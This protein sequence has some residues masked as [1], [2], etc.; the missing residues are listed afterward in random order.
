M[1]WIDSTRFWLYKLPPRSTLISFFLFSSIVQA[2]CRSISFIRDIFKLRKK[3]AKC[4]IKWR[5]I[6][7]RI[8]ANANAIVCIHFQLVFLLIPSFSVIL[9]WC[10]CW[11]VRPIYSNAHKTWWCLKE[12]VRIP[13]E[14]RI[15]YWEYMGI[16]DCMRYTVC[17][18]A[19]KRARANRIKCYSMV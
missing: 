3:N 5:A 11:I 1:F 2:N 17:M 7:R 15:R 14:F 9:F 10:W 6:L 13:R 19:C 16:W 18:Y 8:H 4:Y 12:N